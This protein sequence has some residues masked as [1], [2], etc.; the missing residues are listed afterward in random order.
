MESIFVGRGYFSSYRVNSLRITP[1]LENYKKPMFS[2]VG[3]GAVSENVSIIYV[4]R[5]AF[6][7]TG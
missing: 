7:V 2:G 6:R 1:K 4:K 3:E 5:I